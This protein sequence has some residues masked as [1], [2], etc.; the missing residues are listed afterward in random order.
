MR[1]RLQFDR[2][3]PGVEIGPHRHGIETIVYVAGGELIFEHGEALERRAVVRVGDVLYE[4]P[5]E[6]HLIRNEGTIDAL[7]LLAS[8][9]PDPRR[10]GTMLRR[11][12]SDDEPVRRGTDAFVIE[13]GGFRRRRIAGPGDF[14]SAAFM[15]EEVEVA[16]GS[17][18]EWHRHPRSEHAMVVFEGRGVVTVGDETET[19]EPL[20]GIRIEDGQPHRVENTGRT[21]LRYYVCASPGLDPVE[22]RETAAAPRRRTDA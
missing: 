21:T 22:D 16:P 7:A 6:H 18:D 5:A 11:W 20:K 19:L 4:A 17:V 13:R 15:V 1:I 14:G 10:I 9:D 12:E 2:I 8:T 3:G